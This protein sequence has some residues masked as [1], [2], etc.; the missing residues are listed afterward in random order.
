MPAAKKSKPSKD[1]EKW[2]GETHHARL[3]EW[4]ELMIQRN[5][6]AKKNY[7]NQYKALGTK[8]DQ[9]IN[10]IKAIA[11]KKPSVAVTNELVKILETTDELLKGIISEDDYKTFANTIKQGQ[12]SPAL[13]ILGGIMLALCLLAVAFFVVI[14]TVPAVAAAVGTAGLMATLGTGVG[15]GLIS[16]VSFFGSSQ[17]G[18]SKAAHDLHA[19][20]KNTPA[21]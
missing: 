5:D 21:P 11:I 20:L 13:K 18:V 9:L 1:E 16:G 6:I 3:I 10:E 8:T 4:L 19:T 12:A 14:L 2:I 15:S 7:P 17:K